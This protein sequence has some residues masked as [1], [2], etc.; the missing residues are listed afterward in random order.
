MARV[1]VLAKIRME[2]VEIKKKGSQSGSDINVMG[3]AYAEDG[4]VSARFSET[5]RITFDRDKEQDFRKSN[6]SYR[7]YFK[8]RPGKYRL[9]LATSDEANNLGST[10]QQIEVP[11]LP[12]R[13]FAASSL[14]LA[15]R[16]SRLPDLI[17]NLNAQ[18]L[19]DSDPLTYSGMQISP[20]VE[21][22][23]PAGSAIPVLFRIYDLG[24]GTGQWKLT[25]RARLESEKGE[26]SALPAISLDENLSPLNKSEA[27][28]GFTLTFPQAA[29]GKYKLVI[30]TTEA[31]SAQ[32]A[33]TQTNLEL[34]GN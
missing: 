13:G 12:E 9:K 26:V 2:K 32:S 33:T 22:T 30:E 7:N 19:D 17:Q 1:L 11:A 10:E 24:G 21:N 3:V 6:V 16:I 23:L 29:P 18:L 20:S 27:V 15:D 8:L 4:S 25:A 28:V 31:A 14:V 34:T 5:L